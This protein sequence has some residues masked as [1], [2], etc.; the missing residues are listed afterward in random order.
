MAV[1]NGFEGHAAVLY[2]LRIKRGLLRSKRDLLMAVFNGFEGHAAVLYLL[3]IKRD[4]LRSKR[5][6]LMEQ[7]R[8]T[9]EKY[10]YI[11]IYGR[12]QRLSRACWY[13]GKVVSYAS[14]Y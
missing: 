5:D 9:N 10:L 4:L 7:K 12:L 8:P 6:L 3:R 11:Y 13:C 1:F 2:L 14:S